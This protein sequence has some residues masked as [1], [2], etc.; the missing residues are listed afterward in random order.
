MTAEPKNIKQQFFERMGWCECNHCGAHF[1]VWE[2]YVEHH[3]TQG[4]P[5]TQQQF[6]WDISD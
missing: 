4:V 3:C 1:T 5:M 6:Q 2:D